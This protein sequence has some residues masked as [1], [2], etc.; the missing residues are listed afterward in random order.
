MLLYCR[1]IRHAYSL[2]I[3]STWTILQFHI[4]AFAYFIGAIL[5]T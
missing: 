1:A 5:A 3:I 2:F 4:V